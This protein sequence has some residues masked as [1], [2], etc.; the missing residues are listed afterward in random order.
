MFRRK[1]LPPPHNA[2]SVNLSRDDH[3]IELWDG[4]GTSLTWLSII[5]WVTSLTW[6]QYL[7]FPNEDIDHWFPT[8]HCDET[9]QGMVPQYYRMEDTPELLPETNICA[10]VKFGGRA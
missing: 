7:W 9:Y 4:G 1:D 6:S 3:L 10:L 2:L 8:M 5:E